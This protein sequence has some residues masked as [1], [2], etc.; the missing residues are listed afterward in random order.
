VSVGGPAAPTPSLLSLARRSFWL[1]FAGVWLFIGLAALLTGALL[2]LRERRFEGQVVRTPA[3]V[4]A[5]DWHNTGSGRSRSREFRVAYRFTA[6]DG[7]TVEGLDGEDFERW[8]ELEEGDSVTVEYA[9]EA[10]GANRLAGRS[11]LAAALV[12]LGFGVVLVPVAGFFVARQVGRIRSKRRLL[13]EG[14]ATQGTV[15]EVG[16]SNVT[17]NRRPMWRVR[18]RYRDLSGREREADSGLVSAE[19]ALAW[20]PGDV[21]TVRFDPRQPEESVWVEESANGGPGRT[22]NLEGDIR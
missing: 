22:S 2:T 9:R 20:K 14:F 19:E 8:L 16:P 15:V 4:T 12:T 21:L 10:P 17:I 13:R 1:L 7:A 5:K 18:Y 3:L 6:A 11:D